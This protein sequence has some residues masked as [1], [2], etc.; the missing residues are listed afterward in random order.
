V[1]VW[2]ALAVIVVAVVAALVVL[3]GRRRSE[4]LQERFGP[5]YER[6][7]QDAGDRRRA[8]TELQRREERRG[9]LD[10]R[11]LEPEA[12]DRYSESWREAQARFVNDPSTAVTEA[13][14]LIIEVMRE[15][16]YPTDD[17]EQRASDVSVDHPQVVE[18]Y[19]AAHAIARANDAGDAST[20]DLRQGMVHYRALFEELLETREPGRSR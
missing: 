16:G 9:R 2:I 13:H 11:A 3:R 17:F 5:E 1:E 19:R 20:E 6:T 14:A 8:E 10:I 7:V 15:R 4:A 18:N 12:R